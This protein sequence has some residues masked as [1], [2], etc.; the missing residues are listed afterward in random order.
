MRSSIGWVLCVLAPWSAVMIASACGSDSSGEPSGG[1]GGSAAATGGTAGGGAAG[2][3]GGSGGVGGAA[4]VAGTGG[5]GGSGTVCPPDQTACGLDCVDTQS[6]PEHCGTCTNACPAP[7]VCSLGVCSE[8]CAN[9]LEDCGGACVDTQSDAD[10]CGAC[11]TACAAGASCTGGQCDCPAG[12]ED[13]FGECADLQ[14]DPDHCGSCGNACGQYEVCQSGGCADSPVSGSLM[15]WH[16]VTLTFDGPDTS[17]DAA[18]NPFRDY[19]LTVTFTRGA[20]SLTIPGYYAADGEAADTSATAGNKWRVHFM[21]DEVGDWDYDVSLRTGSDVALSQDPS[22]GSPVAGVDGLSGTLTIGSSDK[23]GRDFRSKGLLAY[24]GERYLSFKGTGQR[25]IKGGADS[26][27][28]FLGYYEFDDTEDHGGSGNDLQNGIHRYAPHVDDWHPGDPTWAGGKGKAIIGAL[29]YLA[30]KGMNSVYF[31]TM[32]VEGDGREVYP[33]TA[34]DERFR[35]DVSKLDQW[36]MVF[37]HMTENGLMLHVLTQETE[38]DQLLDG[39]S[40]GS[41]RTLYY[42]ELIARFGHHPALQWNLGEENT[43]TDQQRKD[44]ASFF[45]TW[46]PY[47]HPVV[48]HTYPGDKDAVYTP[49]LGFADLDGP[50]LQGG[51]HATVLEW[52]DKSKTAG[53]PWFV[54][55]DEIGPAGLGVVPDG[56]TEDPD[57]DEVRENR[58]WGPLMAG[59]AGVEWYFGYQKPNNDLDCEDFRSRDAMWDQTRHAMDFFHQFLPFWEMDSADELANKGHTLAKMPDVFATYTGQGSGISLD[60]GGITGDFDVRWFDPRNGG[61]LQQGSVV[62]VSGG[63][64]RSL[65]A[66]PSDANNDWVALVTCNGSCSE[67]GGTGGAGGTGGS[68]GTGGSGGG[69]SISLTLINADTDMPVPAYDPVVTGETFDLSNLGTSNLTLRANASGVGSV[70]FGL[71]GNASY[72]T[73]NTAPYALDG[74]T[75]GDYNPWTLSNGSHTVSATPYIGANA[76]GGTAGPTETVTFTIVD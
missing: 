30:G 36:E 22:A 32:N 66:P 48:V 14:V 27:E 25:F 11:D 31:L 13:C 41:Q 74:D 51:D 54:C 19:R 57:H 12:T 71:D 24:E 33:W 7:Q 62:T 23:T 39:G 2:A 10:H 58:L 38:N 29:N 47:R 35:F 56:D 5:S 44:F 76:S 15:I 69:V 65:G 17:E 75:V 40:L 55:L 16:K 34:Y 67:N 20:R 68:A 37:E 53:H 9:G 64:T 6:D 28:N 52:V 43:N 60:L 18:T 26:P 1:T 8:T 45:K 61:A 42:R 46:D 63:D 4:G 70:V 50:S 73:E 3:T 21:P 72:R 59:G 49:L